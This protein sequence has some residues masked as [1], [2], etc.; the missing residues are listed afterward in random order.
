MTDLA[1]G[2][3]YLLQAPDVRKGCS[4]EA[5][6]HEVGEGTKHERKIEQ[7]SLSPEN[8]KNM[9]NSRTISCLMRR[10]VGGSKL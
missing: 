5:M 1:T 9:E 6:T 2:K 4:R 3:E 10:K 8:R 7:F